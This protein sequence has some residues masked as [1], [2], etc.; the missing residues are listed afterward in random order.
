MGKISI[1][2]TP[3]MGVNSSILVGQSQGKYA[4][5]V[6]QL[7]EVDR[8]LLNDGELQ[9]EFQIP[10]GISSVNTSFLIGLLGPT[11]MHCGNDTFKARIS[12]ESKNY[13]VVGDVDEFL[14]HMKMY[15]K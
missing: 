10:N 3:F 6:L 1:N 13:D 14:R 8:W 12:F 11:L 5:M 9:V 4:R 15:M 7:D 2:L